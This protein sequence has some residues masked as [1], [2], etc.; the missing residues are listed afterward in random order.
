MSNCRWLRIST[1]MSSDWS[2]RCTSRMSV[3]SSTYWL[4]SS[5]VDRR[6]RPHFHW[7]LVRPM[8]IVSFF[9]HASL[10]KLGANSFGLFLYSQ[11]SCHKLMRW[12]LPKE[13]HWCKSW[14]TQIPLE[15]G[16]F[17]S[18]IMVCW[19]LS[20]VTTATE[21]EQLVEGNK[22]EGLLGRQIVSDAEH[23]TSWRS[24]GPLLGSCLLSSFYK[25]ILSYLM[26]PLDCPF[27]KSKHSHIPFSFSNFASLVP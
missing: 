21:Y 22:V 16:E 7:P 6:R 13:R 8:A 10:C 20:I 15:C 18:P 17:P 23:T 1:C 27:E 9:L 19:C 4:I 12:P 26:Y 11:R 3:Q 24:N 2:V 14:T 5:V 25:K